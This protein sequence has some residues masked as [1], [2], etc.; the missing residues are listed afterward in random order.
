MNIITA[1][2]LK[3]IIEDENPVIV[4]ARGGVDAFERYSAGHL[5]NASYVDLETNLSEKADNAADGGRHPL[6]EPAEFG[7]FLGELG[8][9]P[10]STVVAYDDKKG[11]NAAARFWWMLKAAGHEKVYVVSGGLDSISAA[12]LPITQ[13]IPAAPVAIDY[14]ISDWMLPVKDIENVSKLSAD[15]DYMVIDVRENYRYIGESEP[16]DLVAGHIPGAVNIPYTSNLDENGEFLSVE[17][18]AAKYKEA[19]GDRSP[20]NIIVHCG[21][22]VTACHTLLALQA[23]GLEG[24][25]LYVGSWSEWSRNDKPIAIGNN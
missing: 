9:A 2:Q 13:E 25:S 5:E 17:E 14:P 18:L 15:A 6:P 11:A 4:D 21:S 19:L 8:I 12:G 24:A 20:E 22:G 7:L 10:E 16:I 1:Q 23:A 3:T